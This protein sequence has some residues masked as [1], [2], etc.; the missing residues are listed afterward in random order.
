MEVDP[1]RIQLAWPDL[2]GRRG[3]QREIRREWS[4]DLNVDRTAVTIGVEN[5]EPASRVLS[6]FE[7][8]EADWQAPG[9][10]EDTRCLSQRNA[11]AKS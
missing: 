5:E 7:R 2:E 9:C 1:H 8:T 6:N 4:D 3:Q 11:G 10:D